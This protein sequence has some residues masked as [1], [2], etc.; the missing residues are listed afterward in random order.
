MSS[1]TILADIQHS[2]NIQPD[3]HDVGHLRALVASIRPQHADDV[4]RVTDNLRALCFVLRQHAGWRTAL[5]HYLIQIIINRKL[6]HLLTD[7]GITLNTGFWGAASERLLSKFLPPLRNDDYLK[8]VF[9]EIFNHSEDYVWFNAVPDS[10]WCD[11][12]QSIGFRV[13]KARNTYSSMTNQVLNAIQVLS[14]RITNIGLE[15]EL[16]RNYPEIEKFESPFLRQNDAINEFVMSYQEWLLDRTSKRDDA[17]HIEVLLTQCEMIAAKIRKTAASSGVSISL[18][19]LLLRLTQC[20]TRLRTLLDL[21]DSRDTVATSQI[22]IRLLKELV[23]AD[24]QRYS[25][26]ELMQTNTELLS[27]QITERAGKSG[28]HYVTNTRAEWM[29]MLNSALG[30]GFIV[31]F[32][33]TIKILFSKMLLAPFG[34]ALLYSLNYSSGFMLVHVLHFTIATKQPAM[35]AALIARAIDEGKQKLD[36]LAELIVRVIRSQFIAIIGNIGLA[37]P[38]AFAIAWLWYGFTGHHLASPEKSMHL[39]H[40]LDPLNSLALPHAAIA[41]VC[42]FLSGLISGYYDNKA[43]YAHIPERLRQLNWLRKLLGEARLQSVTEYIGNNLGALAGNFFFGI[44]LGSIGQFGAFFGLPVDIRH[45]TFSSANLIFAI[46]GLDH[47]I[48]WQLFLYSLSGVIL[49]GIVNLSV[50]FSLALLVAL[51]SR[52]VSFGQSNHLLS[53]LWQRLRSGTRDFFLPGKEEKSVEL[54]A[55][56]QD[57]DTLSK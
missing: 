7:T 31:G 20:I 17:K 34:Y 57:Q 35:T 37:M 52:R 9:G 30:A 11:L 22:G 46:V 23:T 21:L 48:S 45:I 14:Y 56:S 26:R 28:E 55:E 38:T 12:I 49:I 8:D 39:L 54:N 51:R 2:L 53:L 44:M 18:T 6:V 13:R 10:V 3:Y 25:L 42:L 40:E 47:Q 19:R 15:A 27:L 33:A 36:E 16:V 50:S 29:A 32:M 1:D 4:Q 24:N 5:R 43:S 41:G